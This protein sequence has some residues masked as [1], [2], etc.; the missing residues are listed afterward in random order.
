MKNI[1]KMFC[2]LLIAMSISKAN[3]QNIVSEN[4]NTTINIHN[5][6]L[7]EKAQNNI[8]NNI[9]TSIRKN[10]YEMSLLSR[11]NLTGFKK[12][13]KVA[14]DEIKCLLESVFTFREYENEAIIFTMT[15][16]KQDEKKVVNCRQYNYFNGRGYYPKQNWDMKFEN[17]LKRSC[18]TLKYLM[19]AESASI[20]FI[21]P[22]EWTR[23]SLKLLPIT[24]IE[25][26]IAVGDK[27]HYSD[28]LKNIFEL[29]K[30][31]KLLKKD[32]DN[33]NNICLEVDEDVGLCIESMAKADVNQ[34]GVED[35]VVHVGLYAVYG[36][37]SYGINLVLTR[38]DDKMPYK[39]VEI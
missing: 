16:D 20:S 13:D 36:S 9:V 37:F 3:N 4:N 35:L 15:N 5:E 1:I 12:I 27:L 21:V 25:K 18:Q 34:D 11:L 2:I 38:Y 26:G 32:N 8:A 30:R 17:T 39:I 33:P 7:G 23:E 29:G 31:V 24:L 10:S 19:L 28:N 14:K 22:I 6:S